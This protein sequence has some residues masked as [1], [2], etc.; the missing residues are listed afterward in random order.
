[1]DVKYMWYR[2]AVQCLFGVGGLIIGYLLFLGIG[3]LP[4]GVVVVIGAFIIMCAL[5]RVAERS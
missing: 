5:M 4:V 2:I 3:A 1:M